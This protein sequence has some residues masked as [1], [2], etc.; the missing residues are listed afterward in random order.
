MTTPNGYDSWLEVAKNIQQQVDATG[1]SQPYSHIVRSIESERTLLDRFDESVTDESLRSASR[2]LFSDGH[3][4][5]AVEDAFKCLNNEVKAKSGINSKD[6]ADLM[7]AAFSAKHPIIAFNELKS[8]S[9][10]AEQQG[11]MELY[12]GA[13]MGIRNPRAHEHSLRDDPVVALEMLTF[14]NHLMRKLNK[15]K[16]QHRSR[17]NRS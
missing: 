14:A 4:A 1:V 15:A 2:D 17:E 13:M 8:T 6:G 10:K 11:Y 12:A 9:E 16:Y 5:S 7:R 3:Y